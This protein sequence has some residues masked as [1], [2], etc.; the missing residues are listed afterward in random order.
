MSPERQR[1]WP[2]TRR[3]ALAVTVRSWVDGEP[4]VG[5]KVIAIET[6]RRFAL[7]RAARALAERRMVM[8]TGPAAVALAV[9]LPYATGLGLRRFFLR[10]VSARRVLSAKVAVAR[11]AP[12][13]GES[14]S[15]RI[16]PFLPARSAPMEK[17]PL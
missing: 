4:A 15:M 12:A 17:A 5:V 8:V 13:P 10:A 3:G 9:V 7:R 14:M 16:D 2:L 11:Y 1:L 6:A